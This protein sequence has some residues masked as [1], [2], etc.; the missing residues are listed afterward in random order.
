[1]LQTWHQSQQG[2]TE[3]VASRLLHALRS[4]TDSDV[5]SFANDG[6]TLQF[7]QNVLYVRQ[8]TATS[9][10][11]KALHDELHR[12]IAVLELGRPVEIIVVYKPL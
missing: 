10:Q 6:A 4:G 2:S 8:T 3:T 1:L 9:E 11:L 7:T 5:L 12:L